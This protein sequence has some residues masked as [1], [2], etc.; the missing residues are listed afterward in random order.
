MLSSSAK[1]SEDLTVIHLQEQKFKKPICS[2]PPPLY[3]WKIIKSIHLRQLPS[4]PSH[5]LGFEWSGAIAKWKVISVCA[6]GAGSF[7]RI[8]GAE[9]AG[10]LNCYSFLWSRASQ[11]GFVC[12]W[13]SKLT[14]ILFCS[15]HVGEILNIVTITECGGIFSSR[16]ATVC[17]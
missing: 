7:H 16:D 9:T 4:H 5:T 2:L 10:L 15:C 11:E 13:V 1:G 17:A 6:C 12:T 14:A 8:T 3:R